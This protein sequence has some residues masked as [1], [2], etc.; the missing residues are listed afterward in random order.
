MLTNAELAILGLVLEE[1]RHGYAIEAVIEAR[2]MRD[3]TEVGFSSI[4]YL[5]NKLEKR[6]LIRSRLAPAEAQGPARRVYRGTRAGRK[7]WRE[8]TLAAL[9]EPD[10]SGD[11][12]L[13]GLSGLPGLPPGDSVEAV[14]QYRQALVARQAAVADRWAELDNGDAPLFLEAMFT[15]SLDLLDAEIQWLDGFLRKLKRQ[16]R[17]A[18]GQRS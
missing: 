1:P 10:E 6:G 8:G 18:K 12:F 15:Y 2:G 14:E 5:L 3:W 9:A 11:P 13:L 17:A 16:A 7:A 4:Y